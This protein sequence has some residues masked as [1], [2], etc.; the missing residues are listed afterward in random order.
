[1]YRR[2]KKA[3]MMYRK[4]VKRTA[5]YRKRCQ[6]VRAKKGSVP[7]PFQTPRTKVLSTLKKSHSEIRKKTFVWR[8]SSFTASAQPVKMQV[9]S[10]KAVVYTSNSRKLTEEV[11]ITQSKF[12]PDK[13]T[14]Q[15]A[16]W[17]HPQFELPQ[18]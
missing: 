6:R 9:C 15:Q 2:L 12:Q 16:V 10:R 14:L 17:E 1:M 11:Q 13:S 8:G 5:K 4:Q 7:S 18:K 3:Q